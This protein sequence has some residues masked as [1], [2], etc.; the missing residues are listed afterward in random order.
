MALSLDRT[1]PPEGPIPPVLGAA[2]AAGTAGIL[3]DKAAIDPV[4]NT[5]VGTTKAHPT[6]T[7]A[8]ARPAAAGPASV[9][10]L[11]NEAV[12]RLA[13]AA[14]AVVSAS[15]TTKAPCNGR[16]AAAISES[17]AV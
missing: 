7:R 13:A 12:A 11:I 9:P 14:S 5:A 6:P 8:S 2:S 10:P 4:A 17:T 15:R 1:S 3:I 16:T